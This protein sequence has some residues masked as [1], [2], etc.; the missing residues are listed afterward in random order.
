MHHF[1]PRVSAPLRPW[2]SRK[3]FL[4]FSLHGLAKKTA[5][6]MRI[7]VVWSTGAEKTTWI[8]KV[9]SK[10]SPATALVEYVGHEKGMLWPFPPTDPAVR[11]YSVS[12]PVSA[13]DGLP[14]CKLRARMRFAELGSFARCRFSRGDAVYTWNGVV[15]WIGSGVCRVKWFTVDKTFFFPPPRTAPIKVLSVRFSPGTSRLEGGHASAVLR[16]RRFLDLL[17]ACETECA[18]GAAPSHDKPEGT[19]DPFPTLRKRPSALTVATLNPR[20]LCDN[21]KVEALCGYCAQR[22]INILV[23]PETKRSETCEAPSCGNFS[24]HEAPGTA[25]GQLGIAVL[26]D[27]RTTLKLTS[28]S[29]LVPHRVVVLEFG[30]LVAIAVYAPTYVNMAE[31][32]KVNNAITAFIRTLNRSRPL[33]LLGDFN[34]RPLNQCKDTALRA[35]SD[36][37][38]D[39]LLCNALVASNV[40]FPGRGTLHTHKRSTLDYVL[41][42]NRYKSSVRDVVVRSAP[43]DTDH[44]V[45]E[46]DFKI[47][48]K[49]PLGP[50]PHEKPDVRVLRDPVRSAKFA[51]MALALPHVK[52]LMDETPK[53]SS[54]WLALL[55][56]PP[57][58]PSE[59]ISRVKFAL[60]NLPRVQPPTAARPIAPFLTVIDFL[61]H[62]RNLVT[63]SSS[64]WLDLLPVKQ[65]HPMSAEFHKV[66]TSRGNSW[67][68][69]IVKDLLYLQ[70]VVQLDLPDGAI[71]TAIDSANMATTSTLVAAFAKSMKED[72]RKAY[73]FLSSIKTKSHT[74]MPAKDTADRMNRFVEH[75]R[76]LYTSSARPATS[77]PAAELYS[78]ALRFN[79]APFTM[80]E[81]VIVLK[82]AKDEKSVGIDDIP[83]EVLKV[84][85][86]RPQLLHVLNEM[87]FGNIDA[88]QKET[89]L[90]PVFKKGDPSLATNYRGI[91]LMPHLTKLFDALIYH[92]LS[93]VIDPHLHP[94]QNGFRPDRG[95]TEHVLTLSLLRE[96]AATYDFPIHGCFVDFSKAFDSVTWE[97][98]QQQL[99]FWHVPLLLQ[100]A[101]WKI[102]KGH[103]VRV[104]VDD[105]LGEPI[106]VEKGVLQGDTL[107]PFLFLLVLDSILRRLPE[108]C[109]VLLSAPARKLSKRQ[110]CIYESKETR[111]HFL[112]FADDI[113]LFSHS[114]EGL[115]KLFSVLEKLALEVGL[116]INMG[117]GKTERFV[118]G[119]PSEENKTCTRLL[120]LANDAVPLTDNY[121][122][123]GVW[124]LDFDDELARKKGRAW[125][126]VKKVESIW[127]CNVCIKVKRQL[128]RSIV[129]P[130]MTYGLCAWSLTAERRRRVDGMFGRILRYCL[131][132]QPAY[133]SHDLVGTEQLYGEIPFLS[134]MLTTRRLS[135]VAHTLRAHLD[136]RQ[137][138]LTKVLLFEPLG[139]KPL[140]G[141]RITIISDILRQCRVQ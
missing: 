32:D 27:R 130:I 43:F 114:L 137:H 95:T 84:P 103:V 101:I 26:L 15:T 82:S 86:L 113:A 35:A 42:R 68:D 93:S 117:K 34:S 54:S 92:R 133:L 12:L 119:S 132:L 104:R 25:A 77:I 78:Q 88:Q 44:K 10:T 2:C 16:R 49:A 138:S 100:D 45:L 22:C 36:Q 48:W 128:F 56:C 64:G 94:N 129:E 116:K 19:P 99:D 74:A 131:G 7:H 73:R 38:A 67:E 11:V 39:F 87:L 41:V 75:F 40:E 63:G 90:V 6:G 72:P 3:I 71:T 105:T 85:G 98:I 125:A 76:R 47:K 18:S 97:S 21:A 120:N 110:Q 121:R 55:K 79:D 4:D 70:S 28:F 20:S 60:D 33:L 91:S 66:G 81:L 134:T 109:G 17:S 108:E 57:L 1:K 59:Y 136:G 139:L 53:P 58:R 50:L 122:Y 118:L 5:P 140:R 9:V 61:C 107:A 52:L 115:Q 51:E 96:L 37:F 80:E 127:H 31:R 46:A 8:G 13:F 112:A 83:N 65:L 29:T 111:L 89:I 24:W 135:L 126:A 106:A 123:L 124:A 14:L 69:P 30:D 141:P 62:Y 23:L 102:M